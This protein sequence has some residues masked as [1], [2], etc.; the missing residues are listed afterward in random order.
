MILG[1]QLSLLPRR[2]TDNSYVVVEQTQLHKNKLQAGEVKA[3]KREKGVEKQWR[4]VCP[5]GECGVTLAYRPAPHEEPTQF[6][7]L[8]ENSVTENLASVLA[9]QA[10]KV[11]VPRCISVSPWPAGVRITLTLL[12]GAARTRFV[13]VDHELAAL[14]LAS[15]GEESS[16]NTECATYL[17]GLLQRSPE[18]V[19]LESDTVPGRVVA[20]IEGATVAALVGGIADDLNED[21]GGERLQDADRAAEAA[22]HKRPRGEPRR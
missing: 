6:L 10:A 17:A 4:L 14:E 1:K 2:R 5:N 21:A 22:N 9:A 7:Y 16:R 18:H 20:V 15:S 19:H 13:S 11:V 12:P 3:I 8:L